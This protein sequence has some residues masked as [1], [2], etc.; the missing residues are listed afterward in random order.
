MSEFIEHEFAGERA[1]M[2]KKFDFSK[3]DRSL[4][5]QICGKRPCRAFGER[6]ARRWETKLGLPTFWLDREPTRTDSDRPMSPLDPARLDCLP[7][8]KLG[9]LASI[10]ETFLAPYEAAAVLH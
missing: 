6:V 5:Y 1:K 4:F 8:D 2:L 3:S 10:A 7:P 9:L